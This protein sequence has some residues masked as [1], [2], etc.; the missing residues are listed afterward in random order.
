MMTSPNIRVLTVAAVCVL[1]LV[2]AANATPTPLGVNLLTNGN[3]ETGNIAGWTNHIQPGSGGDITAVTNVPG[4]WA[5]GIT[6]DIINFNPGGGNFVALMDTAGSG[7]SYSLTQSFTLTSLLNVRLTFDL[8]VNSGAPLSVNPT[9]DRDANLP[10]NQNAVVDL[11]TDVA[12]PFTPSAG[13]VATAYGPGVFGGTSPN[14]PYD[15]VHYD[16]NFGALAAGTYQVRFAETSNVDLYDT[17]V[18]VDNVSVIATPEPATL[19]FMGGG[20]VLLGAF[21]RRRRKVS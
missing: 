12:D 17:N 16:V 21:G 11:L 2:G 18:G 8:L 1:A 20:L 7:S 10:G 5:A 14:P 4:G 3:F 9:D 13:I 6:G 15:W 19:A